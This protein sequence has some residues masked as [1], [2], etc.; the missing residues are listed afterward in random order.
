MG[1]VRLARMAMACRF[2][3]VLQGEDEPWL[4]AA[5]EEALREIERLETRLSRFLPASD[6]SRIN[7][8]ASQKA[9][10]VEPWLFDLLK[11]SLYLHRCTDGAF[12][13]TVGPLMQ[14]WGF[15]GDG[16]GVPDADEL[17]E[18]RLRTGMHLVELDEAHRT[19]R[20]AHEGVALDF[21]AIGKGYAVDEAMHLLRE[22]GVERAF[23]H[24]GASTMYGIGQPLDADAWNVA[25][26][27]PR[28]PDEPIAVVAIRD[29]ALSVSAVSGKFFEVEG[30]CYGHVLDPR[31]GK[32]VRGALL[33]AT[34]SSSAATA[35]AVSTALLVHA[36][37]LS[38]YRSLVIRPD[39]E[40]PL[41]RRILHHGILPH[42]APESIPTPPPAPALN[43]HATTLQQHPPS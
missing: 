38:G 15:Y 1:T 26:V 43:G 7:A 20:F 17:A 40:G 8:H 34:V 19:V 23:L 29:E 12:D 14:A 16:G 4:R 35:D 9:V 25:V 28:S 39:G 31:L 37:P 10:P 22:A 2:E 42:R 6:V 32:P 27:D 11:H 5:G 21:G 41:P 30:T 24:G 36:R 3:L 13:L 18:A 33:A